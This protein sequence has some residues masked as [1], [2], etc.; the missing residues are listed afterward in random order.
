MAKTRQELYIYGRKYFNQKRFSLTSAHPEMD[1]SGW[2]LV[3]FGP[4][5]FAFFA[6]TLDGD[7]L[8]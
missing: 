8:P 3:S 4:A 7:L 2:K 5:Y 6:A 1:V